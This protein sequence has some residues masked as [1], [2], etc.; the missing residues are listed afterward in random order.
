[1][2]L[3]NKIVDAA[4]QLSYQAAAEQLTRPEQPGMSQSKA[5]LTGFVG[6][7][8]KTKGWLSVDEFIFAHVDERMQALKLRDAFWP[9][10]HP[11][12]TQMVRVA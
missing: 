3:I 12:G 1:M 6:Q 7:T 5:H 8:L 4:S 2:S 11:Q 10:L 9:F